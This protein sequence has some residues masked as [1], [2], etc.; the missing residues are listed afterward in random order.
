MIFSIGTNFVIVVGTIM[1]L[2]IQGKN[3]G[4]HLCALL[5]S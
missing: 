1:F 2:L 3:I 5:G 4:R